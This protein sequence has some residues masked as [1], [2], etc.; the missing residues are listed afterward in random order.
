[1]GWKT[2]WLDK[3]IRFNGALF[4]ED[5]DNFQFSYLGANSLTEVRNAGSAKI[6]GVEAYLDFAAT[7][8]LTL[9]AGA[10]L[11]DAKLTADFCKNLDS[12]SVPL[13]RGV[14]PADAFAPSGTR[15]PVTPKIKSNVTGRYSFSV[16]GYESFAQGTVSYQGSAPATLIPSERAYLVDQ[17]A[18][19]IADFSA[20]IDN[21]GWTLSLFLNNAFDKRADEYRFAQCPIF[22]P[23]TGGSAPFSAVLVCGSKTYIQTNMPR[24]VGIKFG[25]KF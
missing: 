3:R 11:T 23:G 24:T 10:A 13:A 20:G 1:L 12:N 2:T 16:A 4:Q 15:L 22:Q 21:G 5:W 7:P 17:R 8:A 9:S 18:Y 25:Q 6:R 19:A 14:C